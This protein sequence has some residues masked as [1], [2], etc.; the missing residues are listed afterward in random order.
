MSI[1]ELAATAGVSTALLGQLERGIGNPSLL[2]LRRI[3][4]AV[5][6]PLAELLAEP[7]SARPIVIPRALRARLVIAETQVEWLTPPGRRLMV[8]RRVL[9]A[10]YSSANAVTASENEVLIH[11]LVGRV[12]LEAREAQYDLETG[13]SA[14]FDA[15]LPNRLLNPSPVAAE[16]VTCTVPGW[17]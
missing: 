1:A 10:G 7:G 17:R 2:T 3:A 6:I 13:D 8:T 16:I 4:T 12:R 15:T 11:V 9:P 14:Y 5:E